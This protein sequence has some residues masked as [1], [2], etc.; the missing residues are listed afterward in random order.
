MKDLDDNS[1]YSCGTIQSG[2]CE[3]PFTFINENLER[4]KSVFVS[5]GNHLAVHW[6]DKR[7]IY[8][9]YTINGNGVKIIQLHAEITKPTM[10]CQYNHVRNGVD[11]CDQYISTYSMQRKTL[12]RW[13]KL[14][15]RLVELSIVKSMIVFYVS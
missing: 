12:K 3:F 5:S 13:K 8:V 15:F 10:I 7:N 6:K 1:T 2:R 4:S 11:R 9:T 14:F